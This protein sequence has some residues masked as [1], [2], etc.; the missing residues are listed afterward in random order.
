M[1]RQE[2]QNDTYLKKMYNMS[3]ALALL[4]IHHIDEGFN[5]I[6][7]QSLRSPNTNIAQRYMNYYE[8]Q[9]MQSKFYTYKWLI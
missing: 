2:Y 9:W 7:E 3:K 6:K 4:P 1:R 5:K 8:H